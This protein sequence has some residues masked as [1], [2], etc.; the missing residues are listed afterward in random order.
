[1]SD[2]QNNANPTRREF[3]RTAAMGAAALGVASSMPTTA[4]AMKRVLGANDRISIG[5]IGVGTQGYTAHVRLLKQNKDAYNT[6][7]IAACDLYGR[8]LRKTQ[9]ELALTDSQLFGDYKRVVDLKDVDAVVIATSDQWHG[10]ISVAALQAGK[11]V[12]VE[13]PLCKTTDEIF[14]VYD[15]V[16]KSGKKLQV[17]AQRCTD[18]KYKAVADLV[19]SGKYGSVVVGQAVFMRNGKEGEWNG[20]GDYDLDAGPQATGDAHVDWEMFR[21][22][23]QPAAWD[24]DRFFR[25]RK[26]YE[27]GSG[28]I[29][30][31]FPHHLHPLMISM[32]IPMEGLQG[33][34]RRVSSGGGLYVQKYVDPSNYADAKMQQK[35]KD[36][37]AKYHPGQTKVMDREVPD[38][39][40]MS[41]DFDNC[42]LM[43]MSSSINE[44]GWPETVRLSKATIVFGGS[45]IE[46]KPERVWSDEVDD[47][48]VAAPGEGDNI[49]A[50]HKNWLDS[51]RNNTQP[52]GNIEIAARAE[53][54]IALAERAQRENKTFTFDPA[55]R[56]ISG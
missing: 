27:Y 32:N 50:H 42:S 29:G 53:L 30:D 20:Y 35:M 11:H 2:N 46:V 52:T 54:A 47:L 12:Y 17:G 4:E 36:Y 33:W 28:L 6:Q 56:K 37:L 15:A 5:H 8:R 43:M 31:L 48:T 41:V 44:E 7:Q 25:W 18:P 40:N 9:T 45:K 22:G 13:K 38:F 19:K 24:P 14:A 10:P 26:Y 34:P 55:T 1:M 16:K 21:K 39:V 51:I 3:L 49:P 23:T